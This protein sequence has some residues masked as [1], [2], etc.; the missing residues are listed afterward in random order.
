VYGVLFA[1]AVL[2]DGPSRALERAVT[3]PHWILGMAN[4]TLAAVA[5]VVWSSVAVAVWRVRATRSTTI[6]GHQDT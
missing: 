6:E 2:T 5:V 4:L 3:G 1:I